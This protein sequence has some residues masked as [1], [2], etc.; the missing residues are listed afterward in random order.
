[1]DGI[2]PSLCSESQQPCV[3]VSLYTRVYTSLRPCDSKCVRASGHTM[4]V[5]KMSVQHECGI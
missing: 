4:S 5:H 1:M 3:L 2:E